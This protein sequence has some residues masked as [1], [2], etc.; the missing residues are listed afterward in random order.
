[1]PSSQS[2]PADAP[3]NRIKRVR[4]AICGQ[5]NKSNMLRALPEVIKPLD[6]LFI[7]HHVVVHYRFPFQ[8]FQLYGLILLF[9]FQLGK[10]YSNIYLNVTN[11]NKH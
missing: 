10:A 2:L 8:F 1:M 5:A 3:N 4:A 11:Y 7:E 9:L 6:T